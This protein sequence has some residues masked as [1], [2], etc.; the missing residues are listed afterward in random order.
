MSTAL[1]LWSIERG[2][3]ALAGGHRMRQL[4]SERPVRE[5]DPS[6]PPRKE[7]PGDLPPREDPPVDDPPVKEPDEEHSPIKVEV[8]Q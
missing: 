4:R 5:P 6:K 1:Y 3:T 8:T 2:G 7:P